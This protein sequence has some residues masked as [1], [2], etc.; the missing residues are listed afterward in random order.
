MLKDEENFGLSYKFSGACEHELKR[1]LVERDECEQTSVN[2]VEDSPTTD[3]GGRGNNNEVP[4]VR[5]KDVQGMPSTL[6][7]LLLRICLL[8]QLWDFVLWLPLVIS[9]QLL[10]F[11]KCFL[12]RVQNG[13]FV[14]LEV[15]YLAATGLQNLWSLSF[16]II[17]IFALLVRRFLQNSRFVTLFTIGDGVRCLLSQLQVKLKCWNIISHPLSHL[18]Q[19]VLL[20]ALPFSST[21]ILIAVPKTIALSSKPPLQWP[22]F[23]DLLH[24]RRF[25]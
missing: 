16:A 6:G 5:M 20:P 7:G 4:R 18:L 2:P 8:L 1:I 17:D 10:P 14:L 22:L 3:G 25:S 15:S 12:I 21:T 11:G 19:L 9:L 24:Y 13:F 23:A